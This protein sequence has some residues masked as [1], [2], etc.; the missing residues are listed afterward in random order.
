M[1]GSNAIFFYLVPALAYRNIIEIHTFYR[2]E[3]IQWY[4][5]AHPFDSVYTGHV[6][7]TDDIRGPKIRETE[8]TI[9]SNY[10]PF[11]QHE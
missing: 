6:E 8:Q 2:V 10:D 1:T 5:H 3:I 11:S 7:K 4:G 9:C